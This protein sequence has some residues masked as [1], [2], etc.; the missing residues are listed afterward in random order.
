MNILKV[1]SNKTITGERKDRLEFTVYGLHVVVARYKDDN[2][3][4][5]VI[6]DL[7][8]GD[9]LSEIMPLSEVDE[10]VLS[11]VD[12][13]K[14]ERMK[15]D[16]KVLPTMWGQDY[17]IDDDGEGHYEG[18]GEPQVKQD[19]TEEVPQLKQDETEEVPQEE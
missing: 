9:S 5:H 10:W 18:E 14:N 3:R 19:E 6:V 16:P 12:E 11:H 1:S 7:P 13:E 15:M 8:D 17:V 2:E 4:A